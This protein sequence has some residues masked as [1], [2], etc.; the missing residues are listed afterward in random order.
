MSN[1]DPY[2]AAV[3]TMTTYRLYKNRN[4]MTSGQYMQYVE[5]WRFFE[6]VWIEDYRRT[7]LGLSEKYAFPTNASMQSYLR[8]QAAH[9]DVYDSNSPGRILGTI[10]VYPP[11]FSPSNQFITIR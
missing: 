1:L 2:L 11:I 9:I 5:D 4:D 10:V 3:S 7:A 8:G 6:E